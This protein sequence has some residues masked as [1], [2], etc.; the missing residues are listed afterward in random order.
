MIRI[1]IF[2]IHQNLI[3]MSKP[4]LVISNDRLIS[5]YNND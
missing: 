5:L 2:V 1:C 3:I 4:I